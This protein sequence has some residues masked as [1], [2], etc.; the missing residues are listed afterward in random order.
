MEG[1]AGALEEVLAVP[2]AEALE[3]E[4]QAAE[5]L[6]AALGPVAADS[7]EEAVVAALAVGDAVAPR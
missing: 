1:R 5:A 4:G 6:E 7:G 2:S 3:A